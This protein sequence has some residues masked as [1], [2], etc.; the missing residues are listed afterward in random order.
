MTRSI[1]RWTRAQIALVAVSLAA[2]L[3]A[4]ASPVLAAEPVAGPSVAREA[5]GL[6]SGTPTSD[7]V[8][9]E[10][11]W[12]LPDDA[13]G[14][15]WQV[16]SAIFAF[17]PAWAPSGSLGGASLV[18]PDFRCQGGSTPSD[19]SDDVVRE[20][21]LVARPVL[22][23]TG[24][25]SPSLRGMTASGTVQFTYGAI[26]DPC[27]EGSVR[28]PSGVVEADV[29][30]VLT[31]RGRIT[32]SWVNDVLIFSRTMTAR[33]SVDGRRVEV[34]DARMDREMGWD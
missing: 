15:T 19:P 26:D 13:A 6:P 33:M 7:R 8:S 16:T 14:G 31:P 22:T 27:P 30:I 17:G 28:P 32:R 34:L 2:L 24:T 1:H 29:D 18:I 12:R 23:L 5:V 10:I 11:D 4:G 20:V 21:E 9:V 3:V 25:A